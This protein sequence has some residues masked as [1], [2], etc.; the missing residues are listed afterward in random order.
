MFLVGL[1]VVS[2]FVGGETKSVDVEKEDPT[3]LSGDSLDVYFFYGQGCPHC[4]KVEPFLAEM[5]QKYP[6]QLHKYDVYT[7]R[8]YLSLFDE[9]CN[10]H[11]LPLERK[12]VP[13]VFVSDTY[14]VGDT[15]LFDGFEE[16]VE[17]AL[18]EDVCAE[19]VSKVEETESSAQEVASAVSSLSI[20]TITVA[21]L[22][23]AVSP[24][25]IAILVFLVGARVLTANR[26][27]RALRVGLAFCL[28]VFIAYFLF[29]LGLF[30]V[31]QAS[32]WSGIFSLLT[33]LIAILAGLF[34]L[35]DV[36]WYGKGGF[37]MEVPRSLKPLLMKMLKGVASPFGAFVTGFVVVCFELPCTGGPYL[38]ILGQMANSTTRLQAIPLLLYYNFIFVLPLI[39][40]SLFLYSNLFSIGKVREWNDKNKRLLKLVG[41]FAMMALGLFVIP[42]S[43]TL[44]SIL[45]FLRIFRAVGSPLLTIMFLYLVVFFAKWKN[46]G[47]GLTHRSVHAFLLLSTLVTMAF[48]PLGP[49][50]PSLS[51]ESL[52]SG[53]EQQS[54][55]SPPQYSH[56]EEPNWPYGRATR[57]HYYPFKI[58][59]TD[60]EALDE[61][62]LEFNGTDYT[63]SSGEISKEGN[64]YSKTFTDLLDVTYYYRWYANDTSNNWN[65]TDLLDFHVVKKHFGVTVYH[66]DYCPRQKAYVRIYDVGYP[67]SPYNPLGF[68]FVTDETGYCET[69]IGTP[70]YPDRY[71]YKV[72]ATWPDGIT[73]YG[74]SYFETDD[75]WNGRATI[76][77]SSW[78]YTNGTFD[79]GKSPEC[80]GKEYC[81]ADKTYVYCDSWL[82][83]CDTKK[84]CNC[85]ASG[86]GPL[87]KGWP[88]PAY[89]ETQDEDC[90]P[91]CECSGLD[92]CSP[93]PGCRRVVNQTSPACTTGDIYYSTIQSAVDAAS[94]DDEIIVCPGT[95]SESVDVFN[96]SLS[97]RSYSGNPADTIVDAS[98]G[99][100]G[101]EVETG[102]S[103]AYVSITGFTITGATGVQMSGILL[104]ETDYANI[105]N[106][107]IYGNNHG[108]WSWRS[109][110][111]TIENNNVTSNSKW[112]IYLYNSSYNT[113]RYNNVSN[114]DRGIYLD[115]EEDP[116]LGNTISYNNI[117]NNTEWDLMNAQSHCIT[118]DHN[119]WGTTS[120]SEIDSHINDGNMSASDENCFATSGNGPPQYSNIEEPNWPYGHYY[121]F[122]ITWT[123]DV[124]VDEVILEFN[125]TYYDYSSGGIS[126]EGNV[127]SKTFTDLL[128]VTYYYRWYA[129]DT[130]NNWNST[131]LLDFH[132]VKNHFG[133]TVYHAEYCPR[134]GAYVRI[135]DTIPPKPYNPVGFCF[136]TDETGYCETTFPA[137]SLDQQLF[138]AN[139]TWPTGIALYGETYFTIDE[140]G[141][142]RATIRNSSWP[143]PNG[144][145]ACGDSECD[146]FQFCY[147]PPSGPKYVECS[148]WNT[149]CDTKKCCQCDGGTLA[150]PSQNYDETQ[151]EDCGPCGECYGLD[152]CCG[153]VDFSPPLDAPYPGGSPVVEV[154]D[155]VDNDCDEEVD[156]SVCGAYVTIKPNNQ[157]GIL[158]LVNVTVFDGSSAI[159]SGI[160]NINGIVTLTNLSYG[161]LTFVAYAKSDYSQVIGNVTV[162]ISSANQSFDLICDQNYSDVSNNWEIIIGILSLSM[163]IIALPLLMFSSRI[164]IKKH[165]KGDIRP[166]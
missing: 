143:F 23:D 163:L 152:T 83:D 18:K 28:S 39:M 47:S 56:I 58:T 68:C 82:T 118:A 105:S 15:P 159:A 113:I 149:E 139:A 91:C 62:I 115:D 81:S 122:K 85:S 87:T 72:N 123:D 130:S 89:D 53:Y 33:G 155:G 86:F 20:V 157:E 42:I 107:N 158:Y 75:Y 136:V 55:T 50:Y 70:Y 77:N 108:I 32:S 101:F 73:L 99:D 156:E 29:G 30:T 13:T 49:A 110:H 126:K 141:N 59:W 48:L 98:G 66:A 127:Y 37:T 52:L 35:K 166:P 7:N 125:G 17:K 41:G 24:C 38:F 46:L 74:E 67:Y 151:D 25:S 11:G 5:E 54:D 69:T 160:S 79:C 144:T 95:Y 129:N 106:N 104:F 111:N 6:L 90:E 132:V 65:S 3:F 102:Y 34:Y 60:E 61:V 43:L 71:L 145:Q 116:C 44:Q 164:R 19:Q 138:K 10:R 84:C 36:F 96:K 88:A 22:I 137:L 120:C 150:H 26:K 162:F 76:R 103:N 78:P 121:P 1:F 9:Y 64:V 146:G 93:V 80:E 134:E 109:N 140:Y 119:W 16:V 112:G 131:D 4:V 124:A 45:M 94:D 27:K 14:F 100:H 148:S 97:I 147:T 114:N 63:Y 12:G 133:V 57:T 135:Y 142:G 92:T 161:S 154:C 117:L 8:E 40:I 128:D 21:A 165:D 153:K 2:L 31:V 51:G